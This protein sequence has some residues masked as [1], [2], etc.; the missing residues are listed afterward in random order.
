MLLPPRWKGAANMQPQQRKHIADI[1]DAMK[2]TPTLVLG[3]AT[4][5]YAE[6]SYAA[7]RFTCGVRGMDD[8]ICEMDFVDPQVAIALAASYGVEQV[9]YLLND[10]SVD[11]QTFWA[12]AT[13]GRPVQG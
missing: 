4:E 8:W 5:F 2:Q 7:E 13:R 10:D 6:H 9:H 1:A 12:R 11:H 3:Y